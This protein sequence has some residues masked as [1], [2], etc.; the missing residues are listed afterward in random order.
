MCDYLVFF[1]WFYQ[2]YYCFGD[3][4]DFGDDFW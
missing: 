4:V 1:V 3:V 2:L